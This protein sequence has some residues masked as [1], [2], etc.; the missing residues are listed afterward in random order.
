MKYQ[1][2]LREFH[3]HKVLGSMIV[4]SLYLMPVYLTDYFVLTVTGHQLAVRG[5]QP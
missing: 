5:M 4:V 1:E 2:K 3:F